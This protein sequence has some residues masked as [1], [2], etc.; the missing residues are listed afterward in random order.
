MKEKF[1]NRFSIFD[2]ILLAFMAAAGVAVKPIVVS[3]SHLITGP[4]FIPGGALAGGIYMLF[5]VLGAGLVGKPGSAT[6][7]CMVQAILVVVTGIYG[8]HGIAS[9]VTY[10]LPGLCVDLLWLLLRHR[11]C[12]LWCCFLG[13][14]VANA[15][16]VVLVNLIFFRLPLIPLLLSIA[17][18]IFSG[19]VGGIVAWYIIKALRKQNL[20][21]K[22]PMILLVILLVGA[23]LS[24]CTEQTQPKDQTQKKQLQS[25]KQ[26][27]YNTQTYY[28]AL[29]G[30]EKNQS[31]LV[32]LLD[33]L[34][35]SQYMEAMESGNGAFLKTV[36]IA[37]KVETYMPSISPV[38][39]ANMVTGVPPKEHG[40]TE[41]GKMELQVSDLFEKTN[42]MEKSAVYLEGDMS[43]IGTSLKPL[44][45]IDKNQDGYTDDEVYARAILEVGNLHKGEANLQQNQE[46]VADLLF[47][48][49]HGIDDA[50]HNYGPTSEE[51]KDRTRTIDEYLKR[52]TQGFTG[53]LIIS[54]DHGQ[55][56]GVDGKGEHGT[57]CSEDLQVPYIKVDMK[58]G[59][60]E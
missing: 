6:L 18:S 32:I 25:Q 22:I 55:H 42:E 19:G 15:S 9:L 52:L 12:C 48:H 38:G 40:I 21:H 11:G 47:V 46:N 39:L 5:I 1:L 33:G 50:S 29:E 17:I 7:I 41:R 43:L 23:S 51:A 13:G 59:T 4:L 20:F 49:F 35:Y 34:G 45:H 30:L 2:L 60:Y 36:P 14:I 8:T 3:V 56:T 24:G 26:V 16:G 58:E 57:D 28:D 10:V 37:E 31:V 44:L 53:R 27:G 54:A